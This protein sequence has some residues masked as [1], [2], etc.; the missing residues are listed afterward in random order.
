ML[1]ACSAFSSAV[2]PVIQQMLN[3]VGE[4]VM[5]EAGKDLSKVPMG[6]EWDLYYHTCLHPDENEQVYCWAAE[7]DPRIKMPAH[8]VPY[9]K[10]GLVM[11]CEA[12]EL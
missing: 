6:C 5:E 11:L 9:C 10:R 7:R 4:K 3:V 2:P 8:C 1:L 12:R